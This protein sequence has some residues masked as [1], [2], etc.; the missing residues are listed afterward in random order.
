MK[1]LFLIGLFLG[2]LLLSQTLRA[3]VSFELKSK[4]Y[5]ASN[6]VTIKGYEIDTEEKYPYMFSQL[7]SYIIEL[8]NLDQAPAPVVIRIFKDDREV[9][10]NYNPKTKQ[11]T[12]AL[13]FECGKT[14][15]Y[16]LSF[17]N[18]KTN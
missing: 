16:Y 11:Y 12:K 3:Q 14:G 6:Y 13:A 15:L 9:A 18:A 4:G 8:K 5:Q 17:E 7:G 2:A 10:N 1:K